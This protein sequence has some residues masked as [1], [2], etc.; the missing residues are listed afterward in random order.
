MSTFPLQS[1]Y[2]ENFF[3]FGVKNRGAA[4]ILYIGNATYADPT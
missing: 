4:A 2:F 1:E 3:G